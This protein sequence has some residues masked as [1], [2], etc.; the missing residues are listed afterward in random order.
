MEIPFAVRPAGRVQLRELWTRV[1]ARAC[2]GA[3]S[4]ER[5]RV[6]SRLRSCKLANVNTVHTLCSMHVHTRR[7]GRFIWDNPTTCINC[8]RQ[9]EEPVTTDGMRLISISL[10]LYRERAISTLRRIELLTVMASA[11]YDVYDVA[12]GNCSTQARMR[13]CKQIWGKLVERFHS[14]YYNAYFLGL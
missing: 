8:R 4:S 11:R 13:A 5:L 9:S 3:W 14:F 6:R 1:P 10:R 7:T 12:N 2:D